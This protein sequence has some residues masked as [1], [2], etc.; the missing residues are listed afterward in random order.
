MHIYYL[1]QLTAL[2]YV[3]QLYGCLENS[4][5]EMDPTIDQTYQPQHL[6]HHL[7]RNGC[8]YKQWFQ[9]CQYI[10]FLYLDIWECII[11]VPSL[12]WDIQFK[13]MLWILTCSHTKLHRAKN[14]EMIDTHLPISKSCLCIHTWGLMK[15]FWFDFDSSWSSSYAYVT[16]TKLP[17]HVQNCYLI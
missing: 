3:S 14:Y 2:I 13:G 7:G 1:G 4:R 5:P 8:Y 11:V 17:W 6:W 12:S 16:T 9:L 10:H 15:H